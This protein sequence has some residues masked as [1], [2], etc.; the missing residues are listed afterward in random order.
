MEQKREIEAED[1]GSKSVK[2]YPTGSVQ[3]KGQ[4]LQK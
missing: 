4:Q 3:N 1:R 2:G